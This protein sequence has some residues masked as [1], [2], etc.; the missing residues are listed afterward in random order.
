[1]RHNYVVNS[2]SSEIFNLNFH[3]P[4]FVPRYCDSQR[5]ETENVCY[6]KIQV[7]KCTS[8]A[9]CL[10][11]MTVYIGTNTSYEKLLEFIPVFNGLMYVI[12]V[13]VIDQNPATLHS[14]QLSWSHWLGHIDCNINQYLTR[15]PQVMSGYGWDHGLTTQ[16]HSRISL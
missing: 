1:M 14:D 11:I 8:I 16:I 7:T 2:Q 6:Y 13:E 4:E 9:H 10:N 12:M 5:Q 15:F 3:P